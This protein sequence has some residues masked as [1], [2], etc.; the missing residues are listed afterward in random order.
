M[1]S[2]PENVCGSFMPIK[3]LFTRQEPSRRDWGLM[4][5]SLVLWDFDG[6]L[7]DTLSL[8]MEVYNEIAERH[9]F[10]KLSDPSALRE[11][12]LRDALKFLGIPLWRVPGLVH[13]I[14]G[15]QKDRM[16][17]V[18]LYPGIDV[19]LKQLQQEGL[20]LGIVSSNSEQ[21]VRLCL[22]ANGCEQY[23]K[24][25][26][27]QSKLF[28]KHRAL[29]LTMARQAVSREEVVYVGD[30]VRDIAAAQ[31]LGIAVAAVTW[32]FNAESLLACHQPTY[33]ITEP[34]QLLT[35][36]RR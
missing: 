6:T 30:E 14:I 22:A 21:N 4:G 5:Y 32:G 15:Q 25:I 18:R 12:K 10:V 34:S 16:P 11:M 20:S 19:V 31:R 9:H 7:A 33:L 2:A 17:Q 13:E 24:W 28:G 1:P 26:I 27:G 35:L 36:S 8:G 3:T 29:R 23:F